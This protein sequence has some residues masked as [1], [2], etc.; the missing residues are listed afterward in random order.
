MSESI[1]KDTLSSVKWASIEKFS[2][3][4]I[5]FLIGVVLARLLTPNDYGVIGMLAIFIAISQTFIDSGFTSALTRKIDIKEEDLSTVFIVNL[6]ISI[7]VVSIL[8]VA[9]PYIASFYNMPILCPILRVQSATL[10]GYA[11]MAVQVTKLTT[12]LN[13]KLL[14]KCSI[15]TSIL[16]GIIGIAL[17]Y[18]G[19]GVWSLVFQ[20]LFAVVINLVCIVW[21]C[22]WYPKTGFSKKSFNELF[23]FGK[24]IL[25]ASL[26][27]SI[28]GNIDS[29]VIGK[30][31]TPASL[32]NYSRGK[33]IARLPVDNING[34]LGKVTYPIFAKLQNETERLVSAYRKYIQMTSMCIFF[35]CCLL[36]ALGKPFVFM[37]LTE[38]WS[39][40][41]IFLQISSFAIIVDHINA[42]NLNLIKVKGRS[43]LLL[44]IEVI[45][46]CIS[47][48]I[49]FAAIPFGVIG[50]AI[51]KIL[52]SYIAVIIN[53]YYNGKFFNIG[54]GVQFKDFIKYF[55]WSLIAATPAYIITFTE[56]PNIG[57]LFLGSIIACFIYFIALRK[58]S[59]YIEM[60]QLILSRIHK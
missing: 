32:G 46:R 53:T 9:A 27:T 33:S 47:F 44:R 13:F 39:E 30:F 10:I 51:S 29:L 42:I 20:N 54:I 21:S 31:F 1:K 36:A 18:N 6:V 14:A 41:V 43:D 23:S 5:N 45:K 34:V 2:L 12:E 26:L 16:S 57:Q 35:C 17:A 56:L 28:Y 4:G 38:K 58:D 49:L 25:G 60:K 3:Q 7:I 50:I 55:I 22:R 40:A 59:N 37:L 24:N 8:F 15:I 52:Y 11:L 19:F 48:A